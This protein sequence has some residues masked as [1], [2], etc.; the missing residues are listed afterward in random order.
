MNTKK[1][2]R[3]PMTSADN[4]GWTFNLDHSGLP[5]SHRKASIEE[6]HILKSKDNSGY[7][8]YISKNNSSEGCYEFFD[9]FEQ[10]CDFRED[11]LKI[12]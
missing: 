8:A 11:I 1:I 2:N 5:V 12:L 9:T 7:L 4:K 3:T 6:V 10:A